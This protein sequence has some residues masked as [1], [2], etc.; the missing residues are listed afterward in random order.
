[1]KSAFSPASKPDNAPHF[2]SQI[3]HADRAALLREQMNALSVIRS[4]ASLLTPRLSP[5]D[6]VRMERLNRAVARLERLVRDDFDGTLDS[7]PAEVPSGIDVESLVRAVCD[8]SRARA[9]EAGIKLVVECGGGW[10]FGDERALEDTLFDLVNNAIEATPPGF[11]VRI[12]TRVTGAGDQIWTVK[13]S[14]S[15]MSARVMLSASVAM[16][17]GG[18]L[19]FESRQGEG[20]AVRMWLPRRGPRSGLRAVATQPHGVDVVRGDRA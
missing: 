15:G 20:A 1:M 2:V 3:P 13:D 12:E 6:R 9:E 4:V 16:S 17:H 7:M 18:S 10:L 19:A 5:R 8:R 11:M 14:S